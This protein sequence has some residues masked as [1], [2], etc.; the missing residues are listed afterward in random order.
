MTLFNS[1]YVDL[2]ST[3]LW[4]RQRKQ[5]CS[6][7]IR[8]NSFSILLRNNGKIVFISHS[9]FSFRFPLLS[10]FDCGGAVKRR[11]SVRPSFLFPSQTAV[12]GRRR[13]SQLWRDREGV[14]WFGNSQGCQ[15]HIRFFLTTNA[16]KLGIVS[17]TKY[18][19]K[20]SV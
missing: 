4:L 15:I 18:S 6:D 16:D 3:F 1:I 7:S 9:V 2:S 14:G 5:R 13:R 19:K 11:P 17:F 20:S 8:L 12:S 10:G